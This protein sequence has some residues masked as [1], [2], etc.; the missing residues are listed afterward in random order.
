M[1]H[2]GVVSHLRMPTISSNLK[3]YALFLDEI[4]IVGVS[5]ERLQSLRQFVDS[6]TLSEMEYLYEVGV[7]SEGK[8]KARN[9]ADLDAASAEEYLEN[10]SKLNEAKLKLEVAGRLNAI[11]NSLLDEVSRV[12]KEGGDPSELIETYNEYARS[13]AESL[14][15]GIHKLPLSARQVAIDLRLFENTNAVVLEE[16]DYR[17]AGDRPARVADTGALYEIIVEGLPIP[18]DRVPWEDIVAFRNDALSKKRLLAL[19]VWIANCSK[20]SLAYHEAKDL[21]QHLKNEYIEAMKFAKIKH[22][23]SVLRSLIVGTAAM[24][25]N[26]IKFRWE[27]IAES[28][29]KI[30]EAE[31]DLF[32]AERKAVGR[33]LSYAIRAEEV[34]S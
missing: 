11:M 8:L 18:D 1:K 2:I 24:M 17:S 3:K 5:S 21:I 6:D 19:R 28:G 23:P 9:S 29:F 27:K 25:E 33:E 26:C 7:V 12:T 4:Q 14:V 20:T 32:E 22:R 10:L 13:S 31:A 16:L 34:F 30:F 15:G